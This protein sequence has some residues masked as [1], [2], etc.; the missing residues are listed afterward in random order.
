MPK[1]KLLGKYLHQVPLY[2]FRHF[3]IETPNSS[4][5]AIE[6][7]AMKHQLAFLHRLHGVKAITNFPK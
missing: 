2:L 4:V 5:S 6:F 7:L 1:L 3:V